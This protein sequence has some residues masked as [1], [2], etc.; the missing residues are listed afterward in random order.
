MSEF[1]CIL[2]SVHAYPI[3]SCGGVT[4]REGL[5]IET[6]LDLDRAWMVVDRHG[7]MLTQREWPRMALVQCTLKASEL[8]LRAPG[9]LA[10]HLRLD[11][12]EKAT[13]AQVWNDRVKAYDMGDLAGQWFTD[14][15][16]PETRAP[17]A[18]LRLVR[19]DPDHQRV[20][21]P[22]WTGALSAQTAF[23]DAYPLLVANTASLHDLNRRLAAAGTA[24]VDMQRF[25][26]NLVL[27]GLPAFDEDHT[28]ELFI[29]TAEGE[30][31]LRIVKPCI[32]CS[33]PNIDP[34]TARPSPEVA[35]MLASYRSD[36]RVGGAV[37]F[38]MNAIV[39]RGV[40]HTLKAGQLVRGRIAFA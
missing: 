9:M 29:Q 21:D 1:N 6:G 35:D 19:F 2:A 34:T 39:V 40:E 17:G 32:R 5:L 37:T 28:L 4:L 27:D 24:P 7:D 14:F 36:P 30:V 26:P 16:Q 10:L 20:C 23:A 22:Q 12:V 13:D 25:R 3:K 8:V 33:M 38:G 15:L 11:T 18:G 31:E